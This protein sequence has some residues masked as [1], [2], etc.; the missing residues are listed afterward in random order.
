MGMFVSV[1]TVLAEDVNDISAIEKTARTYMESWYQGDAEKMGEVL[2]KDI[3]KRSLQPGDSENN[4]LRKITAS[5]MISWTRSGY[6]KPLWTNDM[7]IKVT[8][9]DFRNNIASVKVITKHYYE[10]LQLSKID[11][12]WLIINALYE[13]TP[14]TGQ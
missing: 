13:K 1:T 12:K 14:S 11:D 7:D 6:G 10:Y 9:L 3:A 8:V 4:D 5:D 2:H